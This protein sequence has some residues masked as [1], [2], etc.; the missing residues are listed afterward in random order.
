MGAV[1]SGRM[2]E[3]AE[4]A[5]RREGKMRSGRGKAVGTKKKV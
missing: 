1:E 2:G 5:G 4:K 3:R